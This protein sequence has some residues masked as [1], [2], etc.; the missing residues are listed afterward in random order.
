[1]AHDLRMMHIYTVNDTVA[2]V[3]AQALADKGK[4]LAKVEIDPYGNKQ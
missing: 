3:K 4:T 2:L 1:M